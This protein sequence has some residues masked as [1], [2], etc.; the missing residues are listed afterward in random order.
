MKKR[1]KNKIPEEPHAAPAAPEPQS[2][3]DDEAILDLINKRKL[4]QDALHKIM[5]AM[6]RLTG[7]DKNKR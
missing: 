6:D 3:H 2:S 7:G 5:S 4:Q 1:S